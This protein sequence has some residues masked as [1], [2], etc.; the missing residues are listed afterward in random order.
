MEQAA[1]GRAQ[2]PASAVATTGC[3]GAGDPVVEGAVDM[4]APAIATVDVG[5]GGRNVIRK[6]F[7]RKKGS[8]SGTFP[9]SAPNA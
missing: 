3:R 9:R 4:P 1:G 6:W 8:G 5:R 7:I 2:M